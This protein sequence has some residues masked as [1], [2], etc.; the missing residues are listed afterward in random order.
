MIAQSGRPVRLVRH[1]GHKRRF[2][3]GHHL[4]VNRLGAAFVV[5]G[6]VRRLG[7]ERNTRAR[8]LLHVALQLHRR[9]AQLPALLHGKPQVLLHG[10]ALEHGHTP[11]ELRVRRVEDAGGHEGACQVVLAIT[12]CFEPPSR[13]LQL[14]VAQIRFQ[15][16]DVG[17][18]RRARLLVLLQHRLQV[19][20]L[21]VEAVHV[22]AAA[23]PA[24]R[25]LHFARGGVEERL[26]LLLGHD[27][28]VVA[29]PGPAQHASEGGLH[30]RRRRVAP[31]HLLAHLEPAP[32]PLDDVRRGG[33]GGLGL[34]RSLVPDK[35]ALLNLLRPLRQLVHLGHARR[36]R[37]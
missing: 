11:E 9:G 18:R 4:V 33:G 6:V 17:P 26:S 8:V 12:A 3:H 15:L 23:V 25:P 14:L 13:L 28:L 20:L 31:R 19:G 37:S 27:A 5:F 32:V 2:A 21:G 7:V 30:R 35:E 34:L 29:E 10:D 36:A 16:R 1:R 22:L 24:P